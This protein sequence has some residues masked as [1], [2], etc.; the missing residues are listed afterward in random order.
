MTLAEKLYDIFT[1][2]YDYKNETD[3]D[4]EI[5]MSCC[6]T[7]ASDCIK[8]KSKLIEILSKHPN[9]DADNYRVHFSRDYVRLA[10]KDTARAELLNACVLIKDYCLIHQGAMTKE[11]AALCSLARALYCA[12]I[13]YLE[14][15]VDDNFVEYIRNYRGYQYVLPNNPNEFFTPDLSDA[16]AHSGAKCTKQVMK[17]VRQYGFDTLPEDVQHNFLTHYSRYADAMNP[18]TIKRHTVLSVNPA[19]FLLMSNGNSWTSCH[20]TLRGGCYQAGC[21]SYAYDQVSMLFYTVDADTPDDEITDAPKINRQMNFYNG[22]ALLSVRVYPQECDGDTGIYNECKGIVQDLL[23]TAL[24][25]PNLW[26]ETPWHDISEGLQYKDY[27]HFGPY[28]AYCLSSIPDDA[29]EG[30]YENAV[31]HRSDTDIVSD[32]RIGSNDAIC[33]ICGNKLDD[34]ERAFCSEC[35][36]SG[37]YHCY[38]CYC[39][40]PEDCVS[41]GA[42]DETYCEDCWNDRF[43]TCYHCGETIWRDNEATWIDCIGDYVCDDCLENRYTYCEDCQEYVD[44]DDIFYVDG[45]GFV[46]RDCLNYID[47]KFAHCDDCNRWYLT[48]KVYSVVDKDGIERQVCEACFADYELCDECGEYHHHSEM[49]DDG[50]NRVCHDCH[51]NKY[52]DL[53]TSC[54]QC[55]KKVL[56]SSIEYIDGVR[57]CP[58]CVNNCSDVCEICGERHLKNNLQISS[59]G[60][61][62]KAYCRQCEDRV[63]VQLADGTYTTKD[64]TIEYKGY[65]HD[66]DKAVVNVLTGE[67][68]PPINV[69]RS[70]NKPNEALFYPDYLAEREKYFNV[71]GHYPDTTNAVFT[72]I[73]ERHNG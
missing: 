19:D 39:R 50:V 73:E 47:N 10:D 61:E 16:H 17:L 5:S 14:N 12:S 65:Y 54:W 63:I 2:S 37:G 30:F 32:I 57:L 35:T 43:T 59:I 72:F 69:M 66:I 18:L 52:P 22:D 44:S 42:D 13:L 20:N 29:R 48:D 26:R 6:E 36:N 25:E 8:N 33:A 34:E 71:F 38:H 41:W 21:E 9:W 24:E 51:A 23:A 7:I 49:V 15:F 62:Y 28:K 68:I 60:A 46:C 3:N 31:R 1:A 64:K 53:Y 70:P 40:V 4:A 58:H 55:G 11:L 45:Y 56:K 27:I 67:L